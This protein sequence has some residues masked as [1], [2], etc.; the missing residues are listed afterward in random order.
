METRQKRPRK[1]TL[2]EKR[3]MGAHGL[4]WRNWLVS[5]GDGKGLTCISKKSGRKRTLEGKP[6][7]RTK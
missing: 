4:D 1:P 7:G 2:S 6:E 3:Y 5:A